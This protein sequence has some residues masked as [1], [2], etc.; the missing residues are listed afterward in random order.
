MFTSALEVARFE[1]TNIRTV[2]GIRGQIKKAIKENTAGSFRAT[3]EDKILLSGKTIISD[4]TVKQ[5][6]NNRTRDDF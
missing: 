1:G 3:F 2:S 5:V 6:L 4:N